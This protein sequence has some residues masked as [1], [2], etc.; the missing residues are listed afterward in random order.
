MR[1]ACILCGHGSADHRESH[2]NGCGRSSADP[3]G[4]DCSCA[5]GPEPANCVRDGCECPRL[6][7]GKV[8]EVPAC[9]EHD[10]PRSVLVALRW[11]CPVCGGPRGDVFRTV[12]YDGSRRLDCDGWVNPCGHVDKYGDVRVEAEALQKR[13]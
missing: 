5:L 6:Q 3:N 1:T 2:E 12:S 7:E 10:G 11:T 9:V 13:R 8:V 4:D